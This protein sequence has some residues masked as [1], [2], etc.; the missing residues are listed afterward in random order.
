MA[1]SWPTTLPAPLRAGLTITPNPNVKARAAQSGRKELRRWGSGG[2]DAITC[3]LRLFRNHPDHGDQVAIFEEFW[4]REL[5]FGLNWIE[6]DW[7]VTALGYS[8]Y[9]LR[10]TGYSQREGMGTIFEDYSITIN[11]RP[12]VETWANTEWDS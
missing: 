6:A 7:L 5:N 3:T 2:G 9:H 10:I 8:G 11:V 4:D 1:T 12:S